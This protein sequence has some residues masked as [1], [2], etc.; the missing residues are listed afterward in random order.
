MIKKNINRNIG[1]SQKCRVRYGNRSEFDVLIVNINDGER[2][3][4]YSVDAKYLSSQKDSIYFYPETKNGV[5]TIRWNH[6][7]ENYVNKV[8]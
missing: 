7:I 3:H 4:K 5:V 6:E 8:Q 2:I 1:K